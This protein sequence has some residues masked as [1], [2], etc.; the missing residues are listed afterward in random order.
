VRLRVRPP[1]GRVDEVELPVARELVEG[2]LGGRRRDLE[3]GVP[4]GAQDLL[5]DRLQ[6]R[7]GDRG[8]LDHGHV[9]RLDLRGVAHEDLGERLYSR[10]LQTASFA[11]CS[12][13][14]STSHSCSR[15]SP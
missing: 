11:W 2:G 7:L 15:P 4:A 3:Y 8:R 5:V 13:M 6:E 12:R 1:L 14:R 9:A 10:V